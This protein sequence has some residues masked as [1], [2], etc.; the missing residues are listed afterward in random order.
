V[1]TS[2]LLV[3]E[4]EANCPPAWMGEW[5]VDAG[6]TLDVRRP[7]LGENL[8]GDLA[9]HGGL[10][11]LGGAMGADDDTKCGWL[12]A[13]KQLIRSAADDGTPT[14]GICLGHQLAAVALGGQVE[15]NPRGQQVGVLDVGWQD[16]AAADALFGTL[17]G[18]ARAVQW[19]NDIVTVLP[20]ETV[21]LARTPYDEVQAARFAPTVW[22]VQ[23][24]PEAGEDVIRSWAEEDRDAATER[25]IDFDKYLAMVAD[26]HD[27]MRR[28][29]RPL[30]SGF[31]AIVLE[32]VTS[33]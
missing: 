9:G 23:W 10:M 11:V 3:I 20:G 12:T 27:E 13:T 32:T 14:L 19:N 16:E 21:L 24:H 5:L 33:Q 17:S 26:A 6:L 31:A 15:K 7:Y 4:H 18:P 28:T 25:G 8:P 1:S 22:G 30:A 29:W 2:P